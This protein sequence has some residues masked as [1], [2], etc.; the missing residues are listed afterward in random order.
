MDLTALPKLSPTK[1]SI[2]RRIGDEYRSE[3]PDI[4]S[5]D[6]GETLD[7]I[8]HEGSFFISI[9]KEEIISVTYYGEFHQFTNA[10]D[11]LT[12]LRTKLG[13]LNNLW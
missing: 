12:Y 13:Y 5:C 9:S 7:I 6:E 4:Q 3:E 8:W 1:Q 2:I 10:N 11:F